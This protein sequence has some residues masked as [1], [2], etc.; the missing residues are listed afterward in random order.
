C[1]GPQ[2]VAKP[3][4][5]RATAISL[6]P[7]LRE[8][9][10]GAHVHFDAVPERVQNQRWRVGGVLFP[11]LRLVTSKYP[12]NLKAVRTA[13]C[14]ILRPPQK[15][16]QEVSRRNSFHISATSRLALRSNAARGAGSQLV[17][18][19]CAL[20]HPRCVARRFCGVGQKR[21][22][23]ITAKDRRG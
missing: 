22:E 10:I 16:L 21:S 20:L 18:T 13:D 17:A 11:E 23:G 5:R 3:L 9:P 1:A 19:A 15:M 8:W 6:C 14:T 4:P 2:K 7:I 12:R